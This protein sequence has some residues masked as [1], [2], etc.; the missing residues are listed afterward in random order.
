[1]VDTP[2]MLA[3]SEAQLLCEWGCPSRVVGELACLKAFR[4]VGHFLYH[5]FVWSGNYVIANNRSPLV[6]MDLVDVFSF[7]DL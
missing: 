7:G 3:P 2:R 6:L 1:M 5:V 4:L